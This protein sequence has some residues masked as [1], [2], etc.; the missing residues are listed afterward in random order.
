MRERATPDADQVRFTYMPATEDDLFTDEQFQEIPA[1][2]GQEP[3]RLKL[4]YDSVSGAVRRMEGY[5]HHWV[6]DLR[7]ERPA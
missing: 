3:I 4:E 7:P 5:E 6:T 2:A 1:G